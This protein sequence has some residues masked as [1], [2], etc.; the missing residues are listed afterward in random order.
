MAKYY[1]AIYN[2]NEKFI[3]NENDSCE[4]IQKV[5]GQWNIKQ[6]PSA[7]PP[8]DE[9]LIEISAQQYNKIRNKA[10]QKQ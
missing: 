6:F 7:Y 8:G 3:K 4:I 10:N 1:C 5:S 9:P 2:E